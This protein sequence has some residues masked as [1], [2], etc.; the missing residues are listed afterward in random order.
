MDKR[1]EEITINT[2]NGNVTLLQPVPFEDDAMIIIAPEQIS[3]L[4]TWLEEAKMEFEDNG[5]QK[6]D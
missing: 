2:E 4:I 3:V 1:M 5:A 6:A